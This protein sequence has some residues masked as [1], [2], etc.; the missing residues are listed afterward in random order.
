METIASY[1]VTGHILTI[2]ISLRQNEKDQQNNE[3]FNKTVKHFLPEATKTF[4][5]YHAEIQKLLTEQS[6]NL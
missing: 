3:S 2:A 5:E 1:I 6:S 4:I